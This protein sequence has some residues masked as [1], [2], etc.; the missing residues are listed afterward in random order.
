M[1]FEA[2]YLIVDLRV[3]RGMA[4]D[5]SLLPDVSVDLV[6]N[7]IEGLD[8]ILTKLIT[9]CRLRLHFEPL[10]GSFFSLICFFFVFADSRKPIVAAVEGLALGGGL[11]LA[12]VCPSP[13]YIFVMDSLLVK[14]FKWLHLFVFSRAGMSCPHC[15]PQDS[16]WLARAYTWNYSRIWRYSFFGTYEF[17]K[18]NNYKY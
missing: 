2:A 7:T 10:N 4:G 11:E 16:T 17:F 3:L 12:M 9:I 1:N 8:L 6:V 18:Y 13:V 5:I 15:C 14:I